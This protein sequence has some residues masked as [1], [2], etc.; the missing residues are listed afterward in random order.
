MVR[1]KEPPRDEM[2]AKGCQVVVWEGKGR[3]C[4]L[5]DPFGFVNNLQEAHGWP[6]IRRAST[7][8]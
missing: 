8:P 1:I 5:R 6:R 7:N 3:S 2:V 4:Y